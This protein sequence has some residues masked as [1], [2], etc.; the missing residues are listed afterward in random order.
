MAQK[1]HIN[2]VKLTRVLSKALTIKRVRDAAYRE[3]SIIFNKSVKTLGKEFDE[4]PVTKEIKRGPTAT[5]NISETL[6]GQANL[7]SFIG[8]NV[9][10]GDPTRK[11]KEVLLTKSRLLKSNPKIRK[12]KNG[13]VDYSF[14]GKLPDQDQISQVS[15]MPW[16]SGRSWVYGIERGISGLSHY[17][18]RRLGVESRSGQAVQIKGQYLPGAVFTPVPY[19][20]VLY[21]KFR[22]RLSQRE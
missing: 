9:E 2:K 21:R 16:E 19:L 17:L 18:Y 8:F 11:V 1:N 12:F 6:G 22:E 4:H 14:V 13:R 15:L 10:E 3:A 7:S 5:K 20:R